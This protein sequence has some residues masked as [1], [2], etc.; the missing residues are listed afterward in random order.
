MDRKSILVIVVCVAFM[1]LW[2]AVL[3]PKYFTNPAPPRSTNNVAT[4]TSPT[5]IASNGTATATTTTPTTP[6]TPFS[7]PT[8]STNIAAEIIV[9]TN[10][11]ARYTFTSQGGGLKQVELWKFPETISRKTKSATSTNGLVTLNEHAH[12][13]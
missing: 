9:L 2:Q 12:L 3:V 10:E 13:P 6:A 4:A 8:F 1:V 5:G 7:R 11:N